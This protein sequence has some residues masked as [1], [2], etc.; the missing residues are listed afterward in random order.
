MEFKPAAV[1]AA[2]VDHY[3]VIRPGDG[4][5]QLHL[6]EWQG[7]KRPFVLLHGLASNART[8]TGVGSRLA[9]AG[10][11]VLAVDQ[12]GHGLSDKPDAGY[13]F[14]TVCED[15]LLLLDKLAL[16]EP[17]VVGQSWGGNVVL[18]FGARYPGRAHGL[19]F[20]DGG[21]LDLQEHPSGADWESIAETMR[22][23]SLAGRQRTQIKAMIAQHNPGWDEA[24]IE[25]TLGN[26]ETLPDGTV[27]PWLTLDRHMRIL[28]ALWEQ[29]PGDLY[30]R[31]REAVLICAADDG[32]A[33]WTVAKHRMVASAQTYL[34]ESK[35][36][37]FHDTAHDIHV[38][39]P[40]ELAALFVNEVAHGMWSEERSS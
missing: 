35:V 32:N 10:H 39:R 3:A 1:S 23:P 30:P 11:R 37:W 29:R 31:V 40:T 4:N 26:F 12:R 36:K 8:W 18:E 6:L 27:R 21:I 2:P 7:E 13:D 34:A 24:G 17:I 14:G 5:L 25:A 15:L 38:H 20:V 19:A 9:A 22:P 16:E 33:A 28:R